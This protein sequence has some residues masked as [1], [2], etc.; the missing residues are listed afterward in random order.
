MSTSQENDEFEIHICRNPNSLCDLGCMDR[1]DESKELERKTA[2][3]KL[4]D[5]FTKKCGRKDV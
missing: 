3:K 4:V 2:W 5:K 1:H